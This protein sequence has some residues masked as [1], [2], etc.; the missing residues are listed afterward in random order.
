MGGRQVV[1]ISS[2]IATIPVATAS[3]YYRTT[4]TSHSQEAVLPWY[5]Y[6]PACLVLVA[7]HAVVGIT[8]STHTS[9]QCVSLR[10]TTC[11]YI[12]GNCRR[13]VYLTIVYGRAKQCALRRTGCFWI[14]WITLLRR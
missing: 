6:R 2:L 11:L 10:R 13:S 9:R 12:V 4:V 1:I 14:V 8:D 3:G 5:K 7:V